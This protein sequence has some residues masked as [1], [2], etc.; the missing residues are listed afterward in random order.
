MKIVIHYC[1]IHPWTNPESTKCE[2]EA[3]KHPKTYLHWMNLFWGPNYSHRYHNS[4]S[5]STISYPQKL[6]NTNPLI[7]TCTFTLIE[8]YI[9]EN[10]NKSKE[11]MKSNNGITLTLWPTN[12][13]TYA[14]WLDWKY[15]RTHLYQISF[16]WLQSIP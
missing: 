10:I 9:N 11:T 1:I 3:R 14:N 15:L 13:T 4:V 5:I 6:A 2:I 12:I 16:L 8:K 7:N